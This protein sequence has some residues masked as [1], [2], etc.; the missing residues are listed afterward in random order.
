MLLWGIFWIVLCVQ[1]LRLLGFWDFSNLK[2]TLLWG[3]SYAFL[4]LMG[5]SKIADERSYLKKSIREIFTMAVLVIF[6]VDAYNFSIVA[7]L[8][9]VP[10]FVLVSM[11]HVYS[12]KKTEQ[13]QVHKLTSFIL[14]VG[15]LVYLGNGLHQ[16]ALDF[17]G[18]ATAH[19]LRELSVPLFLSVLFLPYLYVVSI[20]MTYETVGSATRILIGDDSLHKYAMRQA[21]LHFRLDLNGLQRWRRSVGLFRPK[22]KEQVQEIISE[23]KYSKRRERQPEYIAS[24]LGWSPSDA[25]RFLANKGLETDDY[26]RTYEDQWWASSR[27]LQVENESIFHGDVVYYVSGDKK[28]VKRLKLT[29]NVTDGSGG[30]DSDAQ[31]GVICEALLKRAIGEVPVGLLRQGMDGEKIDQVIGGRRV[32]LSRDDHAH[33][34]MDGYLRTL[35][36]EH[37]PSCRSPY[38]T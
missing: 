25:T 35:F 31:F 5:A 6:V 2:T 30:V 11:I 38:E 24:E 18:F 26:H 14:V 10:F 22:N 29:L 19:N 8:I 7:E 34:K 21:L 33:T 1:S 36:V 16:A 17:P 27:V 20:I 12:A 28:A 4:A 37:S 32:R 9:L 15:G 23:I 3:V 13:A